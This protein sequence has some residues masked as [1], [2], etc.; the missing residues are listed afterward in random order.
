MENDATMIQPDF[1]TGQVKHLECHSLALTEELGLVEYIF[2]DKTGTL[3]KNELIFREI[4]LADGSKF[5][6]ESENRQEVL[7]L[8][9]TNPSCLEFLKCV[10]F[11]H[12]C[13]SVEENVDSKSILKYSG[14][15]VDE[16][17]LLEMA[18]LCK[19]FYFYDRDSEQIR[20]KD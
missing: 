14:P 10:A 5:T 9:Q 4:A 11:C 2:C 13:I 20:V 12:E 6:F 1:L 17:C 19:I 7:K 3:T 18:N 15:S 16:V 8:I